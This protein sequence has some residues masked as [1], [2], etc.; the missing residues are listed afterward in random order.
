MADRRLLINRIDTNGA[1]VWA[2]K[3]SPG[4]D[5]RGETGFSFTIFLSAF[6]ISSFDPST[7]RLANNTL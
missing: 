4:A 1:A 3:F 7:S 2:N 6:S 5:H